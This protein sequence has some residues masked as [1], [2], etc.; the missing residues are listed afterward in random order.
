MASTLSHGELIHGIHKSTGNAVRTIGESNLLRN[1]RNVTMNAAVRSAAQH[2]SDDQMYDVIDELS[3]FMA[4]EGKTYDHD[5]MLAK[6]LVD[7]YM[8]AV[9]GDRATGLVGGGR[10][11]AHIKPMKVASQIRA[12]MRSL[13]GIRQVTQQDTARWNAAMAH[14]V[15]AADGNAAF[16]SEIEPL[17][18]ETAIR[19][20]N[21]HQDQF[22]R[23]LRQRAF[24]TKMLGN[25]DK[26]SFSVSA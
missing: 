11:G 2:L 21:T 8:S 18:V 1:M 7:H 4:L 20:I 19:S 15:A 25:N 12:N 17:Y 23:S 26:L 22:N 14:V 9:D 6:Q 24:F 3:T 5:R 16:L 10:G 13:D